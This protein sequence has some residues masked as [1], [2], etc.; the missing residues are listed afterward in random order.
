MIED[1]Q[2]QKYRRYLILTSEDRNDAGY[3]YYLSRYLLRPEFV[4]VQPAVDLEQSILSA[5]D[6]VIIFEES[7]QATAFLS[8][9]FP[10]NTD[11]VIAIQ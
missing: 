11:S 7:E 2:I 1:Y 6:Y 9:Q 4:L 3:L 5:I 8:E 10:G